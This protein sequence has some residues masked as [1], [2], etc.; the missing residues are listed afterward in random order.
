MANKTVLDVLKSMG[1]ATARDVADEMGVSPADAVDALLRIEA[2][3][4]AQ[5]LNGYW[6]IPADVTRTEQKEDSE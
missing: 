2:K 3:G 1:K 6:F 5:Q 4:K